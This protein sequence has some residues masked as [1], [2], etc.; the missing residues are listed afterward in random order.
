MSLSLKDPDASE[1]HRLLHLGVVKDDDRVT[2]ADVTF[3][4]KTG[5]D[6]YIFRAKYSGQDVVVKFTYKDIEGFSIPRLKNESQIYVDYLKPLWGVHV[7]KFYGFY[8][9][10]SSDPNELSCACIVLQ[11]CGEPAVSDLSQL[12]D[13]CSNEYGIKQF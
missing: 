8:V 11:Y 2:L 6:H 4:K 13:Y 3:L 10:E 12:N 1:I 7:P 9:Q 5:N